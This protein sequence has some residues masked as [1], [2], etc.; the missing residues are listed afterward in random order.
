M[1]MQDG[2]TSVPQRTGMAYQL[3]NNVPSLF[4][5][6]SD[7]AVL[8]KLSEKN[9]VPCQ[10]LFETAVAALVSHKVSSP[11]VLLSKYKSD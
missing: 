3:Q 7:M 8:F 9:R 11:E 5:V 1:Q 4:T 2:S 10:D 6:R